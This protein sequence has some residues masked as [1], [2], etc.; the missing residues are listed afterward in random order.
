[1]S[2]TK[3]LALIVDDEQSTHNVL[4]LVLEREGF[5]VDCASSFDEAE[6]LLK[7]KTYDLILSDIYLGKDNGIE[8]LRQIRA[9]DKH[10]QVVLMTGQPDFASAAEALRLGAFDFI[11]KPVILHQIVGIAQRALRNNKLVEENERNQAN[12]DA[13][14]HNKHILR[15]NALLGYAVKE[16]IIVVN[17]ALGMMLAEKRRADEERKAYPSDKNQS[18]ILCRDSMHA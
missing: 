17:H 5:E 10:V 12:L 15:L 8:L 16:G 1:M 11:S 3:H 4:K 2:V 6:Q 7:E 9:H 14:F 13:I 18:G